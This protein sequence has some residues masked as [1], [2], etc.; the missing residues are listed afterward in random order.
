M[1]D[2]LPFFSLIVPTYERPAQLAS[3]LGALARLDYS[4]ERFEVIIVDDGSAVAPASVVEQF[5]ESLD[6]SL[7][8]QKNSGPASAR[9]FGAQHARGAVLAFTDDDCEPDPLWLRA[10]AARFARTPDRIVGGRTLNAL[11]LN[12]YSETSQTIIEAVYAHFNADPEDARF[13][14]S[15]NLAIPAGLFRELRGFDETFNT[16]EDRE[17]CDRW[18]ARGFRMTYAPEAVVRHSHVLT[19]RSLWSQ[20]FGYGRGAR[21]FH[22]ARATRGEGRFKPDMD[23]YLKLLRASSSQTRKTRA[24]QLTALLLWSQLANTAGFFYERLRPDQRGA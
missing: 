22:H 8:S 7:Y 15:N 23:F 14:A 11:P 1:K 18:L 2:G 3:C 24:A 9:N 4:P 16:S 19:L 21:R 13:F 10:L 12:L 5:R 6:V 17:L 20:H